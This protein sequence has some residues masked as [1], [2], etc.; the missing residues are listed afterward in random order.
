MSNPDSSALCPESPRCADT[1]RTPALAEGQVLRASAWSLS[2][3]KR[4]FDIVLAF[5]GLVLVSP[6]LL[7]LA[8]LVRATSRGPALYRHT[9]LGQNGREF[10]L[11]KIRTMTWSSGQ[12]GPQV[13]RK[14]DARITAVGRVLR[15]WK[16]DE[17]PQLVNVLRGDMSLVGPRPDA[18]EFRQDIV[19]SQPALLSLRPGITGQACI[20]F[21]DEESVLAQAREES[22]LD[23]YRTVLVPKKAKADMEYAHI[24]TIASDVRLLVAT[25]RAIRK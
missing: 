25:C 1:C 2:V 20:E 6:I 18:P 23:F 24:A 5:I 9:R 4:L 15:R 22:F 17:L 14:G 12:A 10:S 11:L 3:G 8:A 19:R 21:V 16:L 7:L 13:T